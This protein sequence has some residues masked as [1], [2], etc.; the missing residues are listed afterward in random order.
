MYVCTC[1][2][3]V[4]SSIATWSLPTFVMQ[5]RSKGQIW[6]DVNS[7]YKSSAKVAWP[8]LS[9]FCHA[10]NLQILKFRVYYTWAFDWKASSIHTFLFF[11]SKVPNGNLQNHCPE[12]PLVSIRNHVPPTVLPRS[13]LEY[14]NGHSTVH[15]WLLCIDPN[16]LVKRST[17]T[18]S[19]KGYWLQISW[20]LRCLSSQVVTLI[21]SMIAEC[22]GWK[23]IRFV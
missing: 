23:L 1:V 2:L 14:L 12:W 5:V 7:M 20:S 4:N 10:G 16:N 18:G 22:F 15:H 8:V 19:M 6:A 13:Y 11:W 17:C 3:P 9:K 21:S